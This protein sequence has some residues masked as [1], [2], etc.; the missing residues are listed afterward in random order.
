MDPDFGD[1]VNAVGALAEPVR[2]A[3]YL[4]VAAQ[5]DAVGRDQ[6][7]AAVGQPRHVAKFHLDRLVDE[8]LLATEYRRLSGRRGPGAG[9]PSKLYR[10]SGRE[11]A[12]TVPQREYELAG[13]I[14]ASGVD[15]A[16]RSSVPVVEAVERAAA[17]AG[18]RMA[19]AAGSVRTLDDLADVLARQGYEPRVEG[20]D[21]VLANCPFHALAGEHT[22]LVCGMNLHL[23]TALLDELGQSATARLAPT[24]GRCCVAVTVA[25]T[26]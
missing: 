19:A 5:P 16:A 20:P 3:L 13:R 11:L 12:V 17:A 1:Q 7:A 14:L 18:R 25:G 9:R 2:R 4:Y 21:V 24:P 15:D 26:G 22:A 23:L 8:G 10:R 6:A